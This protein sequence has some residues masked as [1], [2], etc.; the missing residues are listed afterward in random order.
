M[1]YSIL[2]II[3][4]PFKWAVSLASSWHSTYD[5]KVSI[6]LAE[7][8]IQKKLGYRGLE[9]KNLADKTGETP[10][11]IAI[12]QGDYEIA[13]CLLEAGVYINEKDNYGL[14][15]LH[16]AVINGDFKCTKL[17]LS[18][19]ANLNAVDYYQS[20]PLHRATQNNNL[21]LAKLLAKQGANMDML[22]FQGKTALAKAIDNYN[23]SLVKLFL[24]Y[25]AKTHLVTYQPQW[26]QKAVI[27]HGIEQNGSKVT[28]IDLN[29]YPE[30][31]N[32][33]NNKPE[34]IENI[35]AKMQI[36]TDNNVI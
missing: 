32:N 35:E 22:D 12:K 29:Y 23:E 6:Q 9:D 16:K 27:V 34:I 17:L 33:V 24:D 13:K 19:G 2:S 31:N 11:H 21:T 10:L 14:T 3:K 28:S 18:F 20:T 5:H 8:F 4:L 26:F 15:P 25:G 30:M 1:L 36:E 7:N